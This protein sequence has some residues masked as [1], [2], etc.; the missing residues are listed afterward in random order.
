MV[1]ETLIRRY[2][3]EGVT[4][5]FTLMER[6]NT[7]CDIKMELRKYVKGGTDLLPLTCDCL[8]SADLNRYINLKTQK[9]EY[10]KIV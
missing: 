6:G 7:K 2:D 5:K 9:Y 3:L 1:A 8:F 4:A 10:R